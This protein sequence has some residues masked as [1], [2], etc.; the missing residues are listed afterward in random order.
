MRFIAVLLGEA[1]SVGTSRLSGVS[2]ALAVALLFAALLLVLCARR[3][4]R[5]SQAQDGKVAFIRDNFRQG[6]SGFSTIA[7]RAAASRRP[8]TPS[9]RSGRPTTRDWS[10]PRTPG[11][12]TGRTVR[13]GLVP[14]RRKDRLHQ[15]PLLRAQSSSGSDGGGRAGGLTG[16]PTGGG[17]LH[18]RGLVSEALAREAAGSK[19][20]NAA[21]QENVEVS[22]INADGAGREN[23]TASRAYDILPAFSPSGDEIVFSKVTF[24]RR[25]EQSD[26][27]LM[28]SDGANKR[29]LTDTLRASSTRPTDRWFCCRTP[30]DA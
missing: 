9:P 28:D 20:T 1:A 6:T 15:R 5:L 24:D 4:T 17:S 3:P 8:S 13:C 14:R 7:P 18:A 27:F 30:S 2:G 16:G 22:V 29:Q 25:S 12:T 10:S 19:T 26:L 21:P 23:L 11:K